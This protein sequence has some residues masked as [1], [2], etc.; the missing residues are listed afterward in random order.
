LEN[1]LTIISKDADFSKRILFNEPPP[2]VIHVRVGN[3]K[4]NDLYTTLSAVWE[5]V[6]LLSDDYKLVNVFEKSIEGVN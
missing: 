3:L 5:Q 6:K 2:R 1:K 4:I